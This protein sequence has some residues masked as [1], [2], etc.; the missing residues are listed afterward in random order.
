M[1]YKKQIEEIEEMI[2][3]TPTALSISVPTFALKQL[4]SLYYEVERQKQKFFDE[5]RRADYYENQLRKLQ[6][7]ITQEVFSK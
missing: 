5:K 1:L 4:V 3:E 6:E 2:Q 7:S